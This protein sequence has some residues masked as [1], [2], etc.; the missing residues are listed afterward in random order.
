MISRGD[1]SRFFATQEETIT[2]LADRLFSSYLAKR[3][4]RADLSEKIDEIREQLKLL[5][6]GEPQRAVNL[7]WELECDIQAAYM[8]QNSLMRKAKPSLF[9]STL[10]SL[11]D[12]IYLQYNQVNNFETFLNRF[13][14]SIPGLIA[15]QVVE[16]GDQNTLLRELVRTNRDHIETAEEHGSFGVTKLHDEA[17]MK[18][19]VVE[20]EKKLKIMQKASETFNEFLDAKQSAG[21]RY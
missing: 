3:S 2:E 15:I 18:Q 9:A 17:P 10:E 7:I 12:K 11:R 21:M 20:A 13:L 16:V 1:S 19:K 5:D 14:D 4:G 6:P 8:A